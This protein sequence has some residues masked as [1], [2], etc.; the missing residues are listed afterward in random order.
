MS[1]KVVTRNL[2]KEGFET[3][4]IQ[5]SHLGVSKRFPVGPQGLKVKQG[6]FE[7]GKFVKC[8]GAA[9]KAHN[10]S[11]TD[12]NDRIGEEVGELTAIIR[13]YTED[14][15]IAPTPDVLG[16]LYLA[17]ATAA[18]KAAGVT[19]ST[20]WELWNKYLAMMEARVSGKSGYNTARSIK[21]LG[22]LL[23]QFEQARVMKLSLASFDYALMSD[24]QTFL[25]GLGQRNATVRTRVALVKTMLNWTVKMKGSK[26][27]AF[28]EFTQS[29]SFKNAPKNQRIVALNEVELKEFMALPLDDK[30]LRYAQSLFTLC[31]ATGLR[32]ID[33]IQVKPDMIH[34][35]AIVIT[36]QK[37]GEELTIPLNWMSKAVLAECPAGMH[38]VDLGQYNARLQSIAKMC[39]SLHTPFTKTTF[40][41]LTSVKNT[42][43]EGKIKGLKYQHVTSHV[44]RKT[45][46]TRCLINAIPEYK[47]RKWTGHKDLTNF[48]KY[49]DNQIGDS[50]IMD[51]F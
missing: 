8:A 23:L 16:E 6:G 43:S 28:R 22:K 10:D 30:H 40:S 1:L 47:I 17:P 37:T 24:F 36:T 15:K 49:V 46:V 14:N 35:E 25:I 45:F 41:G 48:S 5:Y 9:W 2:S 12:A 21:P 42:D 50:V 44:G 29:S 26:H 33:A 27:V 39:K 13:R 38:S 51:K 11:L 31:C 32:Y 7:D 3:V 4:Y 20:F 34:N 18:A 19:A